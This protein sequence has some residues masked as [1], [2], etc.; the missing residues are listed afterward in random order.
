MRWV[1]M[2][3]VRISASAI[4]GALLAAS[5]AASCTAP[6]AAAAGSRSTKKV[7]GG[8]VTIALPAGTPINKIFPFMTSDT[9]YTA[10]IYDFTYLM[11]RPLYWWDGSRTLNET[12]S[13]AKVPVFE[14]HDKTVVIQLKHGWKFSD[15]QSISPANVAFFVGMLVN[16]TSHFYFD[17]PGYFPSDLTSTSYDNA[18]D[19][20]T[21]H[22]KVSVNPMWFLDTQLPEITPFPSAWDLSRA[23]K[24]SDCESETASVQKA[25]CPAVYNYLESQAD[26]KTT[27]ASNPLWQVVDGP[28]HLTQFSP[29]GTSA[30]FEPNRAYSGSPKPRISKLIEEVPTSTAAEYGLLQSGALTIGYV[31]YNS[32]PVKPISATKPPSNPVS[33]YDLQPLSDGWAYNDMFWNYNNPK[34]GPLIHQL[35][36]RQAMQSLVDEKGDIETAL[37]GY[38]YMD[39]GPNPPEPA[40]PFET[41][42]E[43]SDPYPYSPKRARKYLTDNGWKIPSNGPAYCVRPG[44]GKGKC[45]S[46][47]SADEK[48][49]SIEL[50]YNPAS[51]SYT[52]EVSN[53][54]S[55]AA[56]VGI[57]ITPVG[58]PIGTLFSEIPACTPSQAECKWQMIYLGTAEQEEVT[59][60]PLTADAFKKGG[61]FNVSNYANS[62]VT[63]LFAQ[64]IA[65]PGTQPLDEID[66]YLVK[67]AAVL[68]MP[69]PDNV[70]YE[71]DPHLKGFV[72]SVIDVI[73]PETWYFTK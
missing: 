50:Q 20:V 51:E 60:Y 66:N 42:Y 21:L 38:G 13:L 48:M 22:L 10:N 8:T 7:T 18:K 41:S 25:D 73:Q 49:P 36:F 31:P 32:A 65:K 17:I 44:K 26:D 71:V 16:E 5:L 68:Y 15:G 30:T 33:S 72:Q 1:S 55:A 45:G 63:S 56:G 6:S 27:Y 58:R 3:G 69:V 9:E 37:R 61:S 2:R 39:F 28:F 29:D 70:I 62:Y 43:R 14:N 59:Y 57:E 23:G 35:Y 54:Q 34:I 40:N 67:T 47:I 19:T 52:L 64:A 24:K 46:G 4:C 12:R 53:L 11:Y